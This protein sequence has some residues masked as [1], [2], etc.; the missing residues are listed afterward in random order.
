MPKGGRPRRLSSRT[1]LLGVMIA[2]DSGR[3]AH[4]A[5][6][7]RAL[8]LLEVSDQLAL[9]AAA[10]TGD[11]ELEQATYRQIEDTFK[12]MCAS[13]DPS[14]VP[15]FKG[16]P[17]TARTDHLREARAGIEFDS[18]KAALRAVSDALVEASVPDAY[19]SA[20]AS[21]AVDWTDHETWSRPRSKGDEQPA[22]D[23][24]ASWGHAKR[25]APGAKDC[26]FFGYYAQVATMVPDEGGPPVPELVRRIAF[27]APRLDPAAVMAETLV[28][29][30]GAGIEVKDVLCDCGYSN[31]TPAT[32]S[33]PLRRLGA[34]LVMDLHPAD[35]GK[36]GTFEG[37]I[38]SSGGLYCPAT[39]VSLLELGP[40][41]RG[42]PAE[43][44]AAHEQKCQELASYRFSRIAGPDA[45]GYERASCPAASGK[46][47]CPLKAASMALSATHP[48]VLSPPAGEPA[49]CCAQQTITVPPE[50]NEKTRQKHPWP[51][52]AF[53]DS[54]ARRTAA[55][56]TYASLCDPS[57]G[58]IRR[59]WCRLFGVAKNT[60]MYALC[61]AVR[62]VR[63]VESF[64]R[65]KAKQA[66]RLAVALPARRRRRRRY[67]AAI[68]EPPPR[69]PPTTPG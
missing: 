12:V 8:S 52:T 68:D 60:L 16:L 2:L 57:T 6:A 56:R 61:V 48:S 24:D 30:H 5:A 19:K 37:A 63:I 20:S 9:G 4:L 15:S 25:N 32:F 59:G 28:A 21:L 39:P 33:R 41:R 36:R 23:P 29:M 50:V 26:L 46:L 58:G 31:R 10:V 53:A 45:E 47:R 17:A 14:P 7:W 51:S 34:S 55:E 22:N 35:R 43:E 3:P 18:K 42:A 13:I 49:R 54:Y 69:E 38:C 64:E 27:E 67:E 11:G 40:T 44:V 62:N 1:V 66:R 65:T